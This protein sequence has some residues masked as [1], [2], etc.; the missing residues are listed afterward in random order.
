MPV[1]P[2]IES[3]DLPVP[4]GAIPVELSGAYM[5]NGPNPQFEP[6]SY[7]YPLDGDGMV[8]AVYFDN[9]RARYKNRFVVTPSLRMERRAG[10]A[11]FGGVMRPVP[12]DPAFVKPGED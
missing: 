5:R 3:G 10:R 9:G 6:L 2:E 4:V 8:H 7:T 12:I 1:G 11:L